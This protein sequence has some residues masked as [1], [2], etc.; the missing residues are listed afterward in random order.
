MGNK[1]YSTKNG[2]ELAGKKLENVL[3]HYEK[4]HFVYR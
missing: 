1:L 4:L 3:G 2:A